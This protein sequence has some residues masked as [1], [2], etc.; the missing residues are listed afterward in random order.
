MSITRRNKLERFLGA[1][2]R[3]NMQMLIAASHQPRSVLDVTLFWP[4]D[5][6]DGSLS[7]LGQID[8][9]GESTDWDFLIEKK[10]WLL[11]S[12]KADSK[13]WFP[14]ELRSDIYAFFR[15]VWKSIISAKR[16]NV[17]AYLSL[18]DSGVY[19]NL[20]NGR[21]C[22]AHTRCDYVRP[23]LKQFRS[24]KKRSKRPRVEKEVQ[25]GASLESAIKRFGTSPTGFICDEAHPTIDLPQLGI[26]LFFE[27]ESL[28]RVAYTSPYKHSVMGIWIG[29]AV[30]QVLEVIGEPSR[31]EFWGA[32][33][34]DGKRVHRCWY[35]ADILRV[36]FFHDDS[37]ALIERSESFSRI[38]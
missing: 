2:L 23:K 18:H 21:S 12:D 29:C 8:Q 16:R 14:R 31:E 11:R 17:V 30:A 19:F 32:F 24:P 26:Q 3:R 37:V 28:T 27:G 25:L 35:Y 13:T 22:E 9:S 7:T 34:V 33:S 1:K 5:E 15:K 20:G 10:H 36:S 4:P 6:H 38:G